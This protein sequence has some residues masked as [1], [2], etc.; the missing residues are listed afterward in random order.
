VLL[1]LE[2]LK[3]STC[4]RR[5]LRRF[6]SGTVKRNAIGEALRVW[7]H[8]HVPGP[9]Q[10]S[11]ETHERHEPERPP[12]HAGEAVPMRPER[13]S[14]GLV[15]GFH[16]SFEGAQPPG[17]MH[18][19]PGPKPRLIRLGWVVISVAQWRANLKEAS[20]TPC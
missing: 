14:N 3:I 1:G 17:A 6:Q 4:K 7:L 5:T 15:G 11:R 16:R 20:L 13:R 8:E 12:A 19:M 10:C 9:D 2:I 18:W